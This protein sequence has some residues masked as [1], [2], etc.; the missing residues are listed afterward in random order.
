MC[1]SW[2]HFHKSCFS[3]SK[4][5]MF[6]CPHCGDSSTPK[7]IIVN[8]HSPKDPVFLPQQKPIRNM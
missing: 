5:G 8:I 6:T 7:T 3:D 1:K 4:D 2:H